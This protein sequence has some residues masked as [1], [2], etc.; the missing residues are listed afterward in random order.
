MLNY[1]KEG[2]YY[3]SNSTQNAVPHNGGQ[4]IQKVHGCCPWI[5]ACRN[6]E[7]DS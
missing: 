1:I 5:H 2:W 7:L 3:R 6:D 4:V